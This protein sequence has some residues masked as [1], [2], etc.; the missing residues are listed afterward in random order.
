MRLYLE[1][2][3]KQ[4][5]QQTNN[6]RELLQGFFKTIGVFGKPR[7]Q[8]GNAQR[9]YSQYKQAD[10]VAADQRDRTSMY[11]VNNKR[12]GSGQMQQIS[13]NT[14]QETLLAQANPN[15]ASCLK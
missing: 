8:I 2:S 14:R 13:G 5:P 15:Q 1:I 11:S 7:Q 3:G 9:R 4:P 12:P 6:Q 10:K